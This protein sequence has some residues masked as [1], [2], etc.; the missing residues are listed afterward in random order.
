M[1]G[2]VGD[3]VEVGSLG[4]IDGDSISGAGAG[5]D[6]SRAATNAAQIQA[7]S[8]REALDYLKEREEIPQQFREG[9]LITL[10]GL[11]G[12]E[13]GEG[14]QQALI[15]AAKASPL[16]GAIMGGLDASEDAILR[17]AGATGGLRSGNV[18][19][20][21]ADNAEQLQNR[22]LL[23]SYNEQLSGIQGLAGLDSNANQ[24]A[25]QIAGIGQTIG[26]GQ[27]AAAN[28]RAAA[29][30]NATNNLFSLGGLGLGA[31]AAFSDVRLKRDIQPL[32]QRNGLNW[33]EWTWSDEAEQL[34]L[35]GKMQG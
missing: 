16:Y 34:G 10:G 22:A 3:I 17:N 28:A 30:Q 35:S 33:Y 32:G 12:L 14:S 29:E 15:D 23:S 18:Q 11:Y 31:V 9:A 4:L 7:Q 21:L 1:G 8:Q 25:Q 5:K 2:A 27:I 20:A 6:A 19:Q 13:G 24:I 26:Q